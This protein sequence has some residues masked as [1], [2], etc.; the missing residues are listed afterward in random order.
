MIILINAFL[1]FFIL[2]LIIFNFIIKQYI[3]NYYIYGNLYFINNFINFKYILNKGCGFNFL[4]GNTYCQYYFLLFISIIIFIKLIKNIFI[5][6]KNN[7]LFDII[8]I[9]FIIGM[10]DNF[11]DRIFYGYIIDFI[12]FH[13]INWHLPIFNFSDLIIYLSGFFLLIFN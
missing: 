8:Q 1:F 11:L 9:I 13:I 4:I 10:L 5:L 12:D 7:K 2:I 3:I 6:N